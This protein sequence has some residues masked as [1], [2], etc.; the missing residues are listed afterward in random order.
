MRSKE[1]KRLLAKIETS[2]ESSRKTYG[3]RRIH[4]SLKAEGESCGKHRVARLMQCHQLQPKTKRRFKA[5]TQS[6]HTLPVHA[7]HLQRQFMPE[8]ANQS[9][10]S[11]ITYIATMEGWL[12]LAVIMDLYSRQIIGWSMDSRMT[13]ELVSNALKMAVLKRPGASG[14]L[15]HSDRGSQ[16]A[17]L[18][19]QALLKS[20]GIKCSMSR[21]GNCWDN[22]AMESFFRSLKVE[23]VFHK[24]FKSRDEAKT[25]LFDYIEI[26]Y[27]RQR[28]HSTLNYQSPVDF[29]KSVANF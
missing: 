17:S 25:I 13:E 10:V 16:Y 8:R 1:D 26:F 9:W 12:Y 29:E 24:T 7:N 19:Y 22:A 21:K 20:H 18:A 2:F 4:R 14:V 5:T 6:K 15:L 3:Y 28:R 27:N 11:D 23:C